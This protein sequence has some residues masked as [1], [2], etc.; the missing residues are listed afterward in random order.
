M[1]HAAGVDTR[2]ARARLRPD[3]LATGYTDDELR[4]A[5]PQRRA[6]PRPARR[7]RAVHVD[8][9]LTRPRRATRVDGAR[10]RRAASCRVPWSATSR[11]PCCSGYRSGIFRWPGCTSPGTAA[12]VVTGGRPARAPHT[13]APEGEIIVV[14]GIAVTAPAR[15]VVD[16]ARAAP[17]A[18]GVAVADAAL[19]RPVD[20]H[21]CA[22]AV[23][24]AGRRPGNPEAP[25]AVAFA[26][27][28]GRASANRAAGPARP[29]RCRPRSC[30]GR[31]RPAGTAVGTTD[32]GWPDRRTVGEFDGRVKYG[33]LLRPGQTPG[34]AVV[35]EKRPRR[36]RAGRGTSGGP[37]DVGRAGN[38]RRASSS[39]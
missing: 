27:G 10:R 11:R 3:L 36:P 26:D 37:L 8:D 39:V 34:D 16:L 32:F 31:S 17:F 5:P 1:P 15:T 4:R 24:R 13:P 21:G 18:P 23:E 38:P 30:S 25:R 9:R 22:M 28:G 2:P 29:S 6:R 20:R 7:L 33:R 12:P 19:S 14:D 35:A